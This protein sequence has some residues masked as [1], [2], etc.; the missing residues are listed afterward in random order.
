MRCY[1]VRAFSRTPGGGNPA[2]V[3]LDADELQVKEMQ[4][5]AKDLGYSETAFVL[6][7]QNGLAKV[8]YFTP[9]QEVDLC[10]HA[11]IAA[12]GLLKKIGRVE[13]GTYHIETEAGLLEVVIDG[14]SVLLELGKPLFF[15]EVDPSEIADSLGVHE[16]MIVG[17]PLPQIVS[18]GL[19]DLLIGVYSMDVLYGIEPDYY[20]I[21]EISNRYKIAGYHV[22]HRNE[23]GVVH[24]RNFAPLLGINE[25]SATGTA[26]GALAAYLYRNGFFQE[27]DLLTE[28][29]YQGINM[30]QPSE[31]EV[32]VVPAKDSFKVYVGG[33]ITDITAL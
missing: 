33:T 9:K 3:V 28:T 30:G 11:T 10:G 14:E 25:E 19:K 18:T 6:N 8:R 26:N 12:I 27:S 4:R 23:R 1:F 21:Q 31:I 5:I 20:K 7:S 24:S 13:N 2:G 16:D 17:N 29:F 15:E 32:R 22:F